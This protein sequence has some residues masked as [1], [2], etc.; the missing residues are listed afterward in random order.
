MS[1]TMKPYDITCG[2]C[3]Y[4]A[5]E[6]GHAQGECRRRP[7]VALLPSESVNPLTRDQTYEHF[8]AYWPFVDASSWC[9]EA[10]YDEEQAAKYDA[11]ESE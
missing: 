10:V 4:F 6:V 5:P 7:P 3:L 2:R 11:P 1:D 9:G 8:E